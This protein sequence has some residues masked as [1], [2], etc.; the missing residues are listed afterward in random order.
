MPTPVSTLKLFVTALYLLLWPV[1][2]FVVAGD[3]HWVEGWVFSAWFLAMSISIIAWLYRKDPALL[4]ERYRAPGSGGQS[5][6]DQLMVL[7][8]MLCFI[9]W[10]VLMPLDARRFYWTPRWPL[11]FEILGGALLALSWFFL[12]RSF[13]DNTFLSP[14]MRIQF[15]R[16]HRLVSTGVYG[17]VRHPMYLG[18]SL[19]LLGGPLI[20]GAGS[21]L[22][23]AAAMMMLLAVRIVDEEKLLASEFA[24]YD[25][26]RSRVRYRLIPFVW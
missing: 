6:R 4:A 13:M 21:A 7:L 3:W 25:G 2:I 8:L 1:L 10:I 19:M 5:R 23:A 22:A 24:D 15:E 14:L 11:P 20:M 9:A 16:D 26:Y 18:A 17:I 12:L